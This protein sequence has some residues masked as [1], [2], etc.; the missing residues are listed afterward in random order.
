MMMIDDMYLEIVDPDTH[1]RGQIKVG[2]LKKLIIQETID[3]VQQ[4][5]F[6]PM[7]DQKEQGKGKNDK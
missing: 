4:T 7:N 1:L 2:D 3:E 5:I 6:A